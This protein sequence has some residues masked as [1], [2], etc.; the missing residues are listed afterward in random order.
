MKC[1]AQC[2]M[3]RQS[4]NTSP[5]MCVVGG[6]GEHLGDWSFFSWRNTPK[7][8]KQ[9][10]FIGVQD[11]GCS[12]YITLCNQLLLVFNVLVFG[13]SLS[14]TIRVASLGLTG[15]L[16]V[17]MKWHTL[18]PALFNP[19]GVRQWVGMLVRECAL[20]G[21][22]PCPLSLWC[23]PLSQVLTDLLSFPFQILP[24]EMTVKCKEYPF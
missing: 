9:R 19:S 11:P 4:G 2:S 17:R 13:L 24:E 10:S 22:G 18:I 1:L 16:A 7:L 6:G 8:I 21:S 5:F 20:S 23:L 14:L 3:N 12:A 15:V